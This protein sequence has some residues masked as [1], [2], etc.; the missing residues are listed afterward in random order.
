MR[1]AALAVALACGCAHGPSLDAL[2]PVDLR[3]NILKSDRP[4]LLKA[5]EKFEDKVNVFSGL[6][7]HL[8]GRPAV[9]HRW[10]GQGDLTCGPVSVGFAV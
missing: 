3:A 8:D 9:T 5:L 6:K 2:A 1:G 4:K 7:V 10:N